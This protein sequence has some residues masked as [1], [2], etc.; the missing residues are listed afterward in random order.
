MTLRTTTTIL[1]A[2]A[3]AITALAGD[4][5]AVVPENPKTFC[6][7]YEGILGHA[8][9]Y[10]NEDGFIQ[11]ISLV[12]RYHGQYYN[13]D[14]DRGDESDWE[15]RRF[16]LGAKIKFLD[17][18]EYQAQFN[19]KTDYDSSGRFV[20][21][22][23]ETTITWEPNDKFFVEAGKQK[24]LI[25]REWSTSSNRILTLERSLL[26]NQLIPTKAGGVVLGVNDVG[27]ISQLIGGIY[28]GSLSDDWALPELDGGI[29]VFLS[30]AHQLTDATEIRLDYFYNDGDGGN[31]AFKPYEHTFSLN[32]E[33]K[34]DKV[35]LMTDILYGTGLGS[36]D[37]YGLI[38]MPS[39]DIT[40]K[41]QAVF[42]YQLADSSGDD[43]I[44]LQSRYERAAI[45]DG[46]GDRGDEYQAFYL[47]LNY[48]ICG[49]KL[50]L[51]NGIE[52]SNLEGKDDFDGW[53]YLSGVRMYF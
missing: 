22:L 25:T 21:S 12:G 47:G 30:A 6:D 14:S 9:L 39:Y 50:K 28:S 43:G 46:G 23:E 10:K 45:S 15:N 2:L 18:F 53:T 34:W 3:V 51:M 5:K 36:E 26:T 32:S 1:A 42:R 16:R 49:H 8:N 37:V 29:G 31:N 27:P 44:R 35:G 4:G 38:L 40:D 13:V 17:H 33:S 11:D 52:Y 41:L 20:D 7:V 48:Y 24:A 19:I